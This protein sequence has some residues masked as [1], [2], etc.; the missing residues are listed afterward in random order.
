MNANIE[1]AHQSPSRPLEANEPV[2]KTEELPKLSAQEF[3]VYN[4]M[5]EH[6]NYFHEH[7]RQTWNLL[8][9]AASSGA[10]P[11][12]MSIRAYLN[13]GEQFAHHLTVHHTIE[14]RHIF[15]VLARKMPAFREELELLTQHTQ[16]HEGLVKFEKYIEECKSGERELQMGEVKGIMDTF[17][18]VLWTHLDQEV[19][20]LGAENMR[21]FWTMNEMRQMP[22]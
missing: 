19:A 21:K 7:F 5:A 3:R 8:Y 9:T 10:R 17:G 20:Q 18:T 22:M 13:T 1:Q 4:S 2:A 12:G 14:E 15:P 6:M 11:A 16:I